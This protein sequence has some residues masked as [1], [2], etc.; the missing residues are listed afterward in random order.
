MIYPENIAPQILK[1]SVCMRCVL[2]IEHYA[3]AIGV[4][5]APWLIHLL[6]LGGCNVSSVDQA[7]HTNFL[8]SWRLSLRSL[9]KCSTSRCWKTRPIGGSLRVS[10]TIN[11]N[12]QNVYKKNF[13]INK[14]GKK[15]FNPH[16]FGTFMCS[17]NPLPY[18]RNYPIELEGNLGLS[19]CKRA[20]YWNIS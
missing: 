15:C 17:R 1:I 2:N 16:F 18:K 20:V 8:Q 9:Q 14:N 12:T 19:V 7:S 5:N 3:C 11:S 4:S 6:Y 10:V 13:F